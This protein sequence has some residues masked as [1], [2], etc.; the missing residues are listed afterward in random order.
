MEAHGPGKLTP[1]INHRTHVCGIRSFL[2][3]VRWQCQAQFL[4]SLAEVHSVE[5]EL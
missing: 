3:L 1:K 5:T 4:V 2:A